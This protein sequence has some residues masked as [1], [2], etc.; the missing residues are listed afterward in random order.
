M[1]HG[2]MKCAEFSSL[3][4]VQRRVFC[5]ISNENVRVHRRCGISSQPE[6]LRFQE[7][8]SS[9]Q[10]LYQSRIRI[11]NIITFRYYTN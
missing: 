7:G 3:E 5:K 10:L 11:S 4:W 1:K 8:Q 2:V 9:M 6:R